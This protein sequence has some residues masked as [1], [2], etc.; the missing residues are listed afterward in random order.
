LED[1]KG[2]LIDDSFFVVTPFCIFQVNLAINYNLNITNQK[3]GVLQKKSLSSML[4]GLTIADLLGA[5]GC[6]RPHITEGDAPKITGF[7][8]RYN[9]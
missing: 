8:V 1:A 6:L 9:N 3:L 7:K 2:S 5:I 4:N